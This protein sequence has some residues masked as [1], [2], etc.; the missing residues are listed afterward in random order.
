MQ[1]HL[2]SFLEA[3]ARAVTAAW[4]FPES[5][6]RLPLRAGFTF[7][8]ARAIVPYLHDL[9]SPT[10]KNGMKLTDQRSPFSFKTDS[11]YRC[12]RYISIPTS[13]RCV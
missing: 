8:E 1:D 6:Y 7:R 3:V 5:T 10:A 2:P 11:P 4:C 12:A 13:A 9:L